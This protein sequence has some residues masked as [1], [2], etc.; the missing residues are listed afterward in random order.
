MLKAV[1]EKN[2]VKN[3]VDYITP[4]EQI[5]PPQ[6]DPLMLKQ[7]ELEER[8]VAALEKQAETTAAKVQANAE[9]E[10]L[11]VEMAQMKQAFEEMMRER[12]EERKDFD[13]SAR[14]AIATEELSMA[15]AAD[16]EQTRV[17][18]SPNS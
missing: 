6:P 2:G 8:K 14:Y 16:P 18:V 11:K 4:P 15:K 10:L 17:I 7:V 12:V 3:T 1:F 13:T 5:P 9:L